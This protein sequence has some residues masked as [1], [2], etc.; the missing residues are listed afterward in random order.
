RTALIKARRYRKKTESGKWQ[1]GTAISFFGKEALKLWN[2][3]ISD[4]EI[5]FSALK[6]DEGKWEI[7]VPL[8]KEKQG[9]PE[10][11]RGIISPH[12]EGVENP[13]IKITLITANG[14][15]E[16]T[17]FKNDIPPNPWVRWIFL[18]LLKI[19]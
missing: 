19:D 6:T 13:F 8:L 14:R 9:G 15:I 2:F 18:P 11:G 17:I 10:D 3:F 12:I 16:R 4:E 7:S 1:T 5:H